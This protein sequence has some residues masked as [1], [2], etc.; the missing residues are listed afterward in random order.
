MNELIVVMVMLMSTGSSIR[1]GDLQQQRIRVGGPK[2][3]I[4]YAVSTKEHGGGTSTRSQT[5]GT[6]VAAF[7]MS[8]SNTWPRS[9]ESNGRGK[10]KGY[11]IGTT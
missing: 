4:V 5:K 2:R 1:Y 11:G 6:R 7:G 8:R 9:L 10:G 3:G